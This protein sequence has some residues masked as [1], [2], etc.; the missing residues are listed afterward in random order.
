MCASTAITLAILTTSLQL[1]LSKLCACI[2]FIIGNSERSELSNVRVHRERL[3]VKRHNPNMELI[4]L[5]HIQSR[6]MM[7]S[8]LL[9]Q[10]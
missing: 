2:I 9:E 1:E 3:Q 6:E 10:A 4:S 8:L 5:P 7:L